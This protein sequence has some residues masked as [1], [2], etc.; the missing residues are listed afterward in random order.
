MTSS[1][2]DSVLLVGFGG[3][4]HLDEIRPFLANVTRGRPIPAERLE[5][6]PTATACVRC[7]QAF[8]R[9]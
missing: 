1:R 8:E 9:R 7:K 5:V 3:P 2:F 4:T 6:Y